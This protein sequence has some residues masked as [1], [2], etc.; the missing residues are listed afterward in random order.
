MLLLVSIASL[1][2]LSQL[3][4]VSLCGETAIKMSWTNIFIPE[5]T[6]IL[7]CNVNL[8]LQ[9]MGIRYLCRLLEATEANLWRKNEMLNPL[10]NIFFLFLTKNENISVMKTII[11]HL[12]ALTFTCHSGTMRLMYCRFHKAFHSSLQKY[13]FILVF[14]FIIMTEGCIQ[15]HMFALNLSY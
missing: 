14:L 12:I 11:T 3:W 9:W 6:E 8:S 1:T 2:D 10:L 7:K 13:Y 4:N 15:D 5:G